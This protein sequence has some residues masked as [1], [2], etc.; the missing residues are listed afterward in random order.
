MTDLL[1]VVIT[2]AFFGVA[3]L[4]VRGCDAII[5][6]DE[7]SEVATDDVTETHEEVSA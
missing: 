1:L 2:I 4:L 7:D 6:P 3:A 5:G